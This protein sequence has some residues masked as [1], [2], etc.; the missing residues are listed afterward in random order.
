MYMHIYRIYGCTHYIYTFIQS[1]YMDIHI[2][3][4]MSFLQIVFTTVI[5]PSLPVMSD[6]VVYLI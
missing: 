5:K 6:P 3:M 2:L 4:M 1:K